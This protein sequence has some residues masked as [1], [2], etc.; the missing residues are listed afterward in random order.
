MSGGGTFHVMEKSDIPAEGEGARRILVTGS[1]D[2]VDERAVSVALEHEFLRLGAC[3]ST[4]LVNG[5]CS[6]G[7]DALSARIWRGRG[8]PVEQHPLGQDMPHGRLALAR[9]NAAMVALGADVCVAFPLKRSGDVSDC[10]GRARKAGI[11]VVVVSLH[12]KPEVSAW[13]EADFFAK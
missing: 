1:R 6:T 3:P 12:A 5:G 7:I 11:P 10:M 9:R 13:F 8:L 2:W 4:T